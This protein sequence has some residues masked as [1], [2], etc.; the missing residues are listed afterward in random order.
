MI[1]LKGAVTMSEIKIREYTESDRE[2]LAEFKLSTQQTEYTSLPL[3]VL[4]DALSDSNRRACVVENEEQE[5]IGFFVLHKHYQ[6]EGYDTPRD[7]V[8]VRSLSINE[9]LQGRGYGTKVA[10]NL[11]L[12]VQSA[13]SNFDHLYLVVDTDNAAAWNLYERSGFIHTATKEDGP[14]GE[15]R[16]YYLDLDRN[17]VSNLKLIRDESVEYPDVKIKLIMDNRFEVGDINGTINNEVL[18]IN[19]V[20][21][22][23]A[24]RH[25]GIA[26]GGLRQIGTFIRRHI[27]EVRQLSVYVDED[28]QLNKLFEHVGFT[29]FE[30]TDGREL[31]KKYVQY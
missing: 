13:F 14:I 22:N 9:A 7:V 10:M 19:H 20:E 5:I 6:H 31:Y 21:T 16:L 8:Y 28:R 2:H 12:Y 27:P 3:D 30:E 25:K 4:D 29:R 18:H 15:E 1:E 26:S 11:P 24:H 17:Y 23:E